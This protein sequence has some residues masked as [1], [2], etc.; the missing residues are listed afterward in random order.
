MS[1]KLDRATVER[2]SA[3]DRWS[4][5]VDLRGPRGGLIALDACMTRGGEVKAFRDERGNVVDPVPGW[6]TARVCA[7]WNARWA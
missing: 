4:V 1:N 7:A 2:V 5:Q 6:L 3:Q